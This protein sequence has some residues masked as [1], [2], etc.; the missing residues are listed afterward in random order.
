[1]HHGCDRGSLGEPP[2]L[3]CPQGWNGRLIVRAP[4][5]T[6]RVVPQAPGAPAKSVSAGCRSRRDAVV[7]PVRSQLHLSYII[8]RRVPCRGSPT[9]LH[10]ENAVGLN[11]SL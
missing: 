8:S 6:W 9:R 5:Q 1:M 3:T 7:S 2:D 11:A 4:L 10:D